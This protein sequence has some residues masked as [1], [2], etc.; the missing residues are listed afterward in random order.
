MKRKLDFINKRWYHR[1]HY[2]VD[3]DHD[4]DDAVVLYRVAIK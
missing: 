2:V 4:D 1:S 3:D